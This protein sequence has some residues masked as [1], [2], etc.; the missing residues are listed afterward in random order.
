[1]GALQEA[2]ALALISFP[3]AVGSDAAH[4]LGDW[5]AADA[6]SAEALQLAVEAG[7]RGTETMALVVKAWLAAGRGREQELEAMAER[8]FEL[9]EEGGLG[10]VA[11][12]VRAAQGFGLLGL[13]RIG[14][15]IEVLEDVAGR[16][17]SMGLRSP[18]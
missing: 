15:A 17:S 1:M 3:M 16:A 18:R 5:D 13:A 4:R 9:A 6:E 12:F 11:L 2:D 7:E 14:E 8:T 10:S